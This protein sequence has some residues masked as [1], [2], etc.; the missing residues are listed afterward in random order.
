MPAKIKLESIA[1]E[2]KQRIIDAYNRGIGS[3]RIK[4]ETGFSARTMRQV[5]DAAGIP[6]MPIGG[7]GFDNTV[8]VSQSDRDKI[9]ALYTSGKGCEAIAQLVPQGERIVKRVLDGAG[10]IR[11]DRSTGLTKYVA[12]NPENKICTR[13]G[14]EKLKSEF[15]LTASKRSLRCYCRNC[16]TEITRINIL[17]RLGMTIEQYEDMK[18]EQNNLCACCGQPE[19]YASSAGNAAKELAVDH[20]HQTGKVRHL[21]CHRCNISLGFLEEDPE[22]CEL[23]KQ[24]ALRIRKEG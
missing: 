8:Y 23:L 1:A 9:V 21:L 20:N 11:R 19:Q 13:C 10:I 17:K 22:L 12:G 16:C 3:T 15:S 4:Q 7:L 24:Y 5:I 6:R 18:S 14:V 2:D